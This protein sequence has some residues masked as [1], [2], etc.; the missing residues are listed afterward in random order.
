LTGVEAIAIHQYDWL[1][2][3]NSEGG[4]KIGKLGKP[5]RVLT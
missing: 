4:W 5:T 3:K 1:I 2:G